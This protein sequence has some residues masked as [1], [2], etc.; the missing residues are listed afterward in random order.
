MTDMRRRRSQAGHRE[1]EEEKSELLIFSAVS[2]LV[3]Q[4]GLKCNFK[5]SFSVT[6]TIF[7]FLGR[8]EQLLFCTYVLRRGA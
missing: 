2:T 4:T 6:V 8:P 5:V 1:Q 3:L 7:C